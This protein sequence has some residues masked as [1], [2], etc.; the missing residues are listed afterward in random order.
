[1]TLHRENPPPPRIGWHLIGRDKIWSQRYQAI[2]VS[3][4]EAAQIGRLKYVLSHGPKEGL[5]A[6][7]L[8]PGRQGTGKQAKTAGNSD[9]L[10]LQPPRPPSTLPWSMG[11]RQ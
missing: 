2:L 8:A 11:S 10:D 5:V 9:S 3:A 1:V 6:N 4:E 7:W